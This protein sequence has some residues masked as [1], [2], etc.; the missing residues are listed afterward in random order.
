VLATNPKAENL[1]ELR[2]A[3]RTCELAQRAGVL[4]GGN[5][6]AYLGTLAAAANIRKFPEAVT[7][8]Q[9]ALQLPPAQTNS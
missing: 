6:P 7:I 8:L 9:K 2:N 3:P 1:S 5:N 4:S